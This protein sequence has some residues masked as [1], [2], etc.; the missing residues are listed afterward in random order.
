[1]V[2]STSDRWSRNE[3]TDTLRMRA[4]SAL[5]LLKHTKES[6]QRMAALLVT[7]NYIWNVFLTLITCCRTPRAVCWCRPSS[8]L[9]PGPE[10]AERWWPPA[11]KGRE[12]PES[13]TEVKED[14]E[15]VAFSTQCKGTFSIPQTTFIPLFVNPNLTVTWERGKRAGWH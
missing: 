4:S 1:M 14:L 2:S 8:A 13:C 3:F 15:L 11:T 6:V 10:S 5:H 12:R 9:C 7:L